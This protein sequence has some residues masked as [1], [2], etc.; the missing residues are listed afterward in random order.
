M[1]RRRK[2]AA[3]AADRSG[4]FSAPAAVFGLISYDGDDPL[5]DVPQTGDVEA[6]SLAE[7]AQIERTIA[8]RKEVAE[9]DRRRYAADADFWLGC[10]F[11]SRAQKEA[12][13]RA[14]PQLPCDEGQY[15]DGRYL[16]GLLG[17]EL[18][19][20][21]IP[22][23]PK[24]RINSDYAALAMPI[25]GPTPKRRRKIRHSCRWDREVLQPSSA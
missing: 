7:V 24:K 18:P 11:Q 8:Q 17:V 1:A 14:L 19:E 10:V 16:A 6:D 3:F 25:H 4:A 9:Q 2:G 23:S 21:A 22:S 20:V 13:L 15:V 12:F 5:D